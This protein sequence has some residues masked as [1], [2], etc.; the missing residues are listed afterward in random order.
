[1]QP[2]NAPTKQKLNVQKCFSLFYKFLTTFSIPEVYLLTDKWKEDYERL[3]VLRKQNIKFSF[4]SL[5]GVL[6]FSL[7]FLH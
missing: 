1:M 5:H 6:P 2:T 7:K 4:P 3:V